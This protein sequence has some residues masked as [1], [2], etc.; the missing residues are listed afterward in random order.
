MIQ[1]QHTLNGQSEGYSCYI[2]LPENMKGQNLKGYPYFDFAAAYQQDTDNPAVHSDEMSATEFY[3]TLLLG[4]ITFLAFVIG[5]ATGF[6]YL[7]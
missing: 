3:L 5:F 7:D 6:A 2:Q 4:G 1:S